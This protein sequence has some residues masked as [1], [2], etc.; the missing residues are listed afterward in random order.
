MRLVVGAAAMSSVINTPRQACWIS[1]G[2][3]Q[4]DLTAQALRVRVMSLVCSP[5]RGKPSIVRVKLSI[6]L[7]TAMTSTITENHFEYQQLAA[8]LRRVCN[9]RRVRRS[10]FYRAN[11]AELIRLL[12]EPRVYVFPGADRVSNPF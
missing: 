10:E 7:L 11:K 1:H 12:D 5:V 8:E 6:N 3:Y 9:L 4:N 2:A